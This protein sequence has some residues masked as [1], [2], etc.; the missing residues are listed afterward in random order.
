MNA[1]PDC[2]TAEAFP[3]SV[4][5]SSECLSCSARALAGGPAFFDSVR[6]GSW[7]KTYRDAVA[8]LFGELH[9]GEGHKRVMEWHQRIE[10]AA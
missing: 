9:A 2:V 4:R 8:S 7:S 10:A 1:C 6:C 5:F 3:R